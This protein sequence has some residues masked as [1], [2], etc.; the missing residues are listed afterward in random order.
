MLAISF[1][2]PKEY[3]SGAFNKFVT[4]ITAGEYCHCELV[5]EMASKDIM[6]I[7]KEV[8][9]KATTGNYDKEDCN[10]TLSQI[11]NFFFSTHFRKH[12]QSND[13]I[14]LSFSLLWG[15]P[16]SVRTLQKM[17]HDSWFKIPEVTDDN[18]NIVSIP[19]KTPKKISETVKFAIE[20]LGKD[21]NQSGALFSW[22]PFTQNEH[23]R[24]QKTYYCSE[25][26]ATALQRIGYIEE[27]NALHCT[28]NSLYNTLSKNNRIHNDT[29]TT[30]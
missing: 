3:F 27:V 4:W 20:E 26:C 19:Y 12:I 29:K 24:K 21:Y 6:D 5:V 28:P 22:L 10:R 11:E 2:R 9:T 14:A 7:V 30:L 13:R 1:Y 18:A 16:M 15:E 8:Y 17:S 23:K 25:F